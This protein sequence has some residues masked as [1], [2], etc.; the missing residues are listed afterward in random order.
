MKFINSIEISKDDLLKSGGQRNFNINGD[1]GA[2]FNLEIT[3]AAGKF[4]NFIT[5]TF[6]TNAITSTT[7]VTSDAATGNVVYIT[8]ANSNIKIGMT[9]TGNGVSERV[10]VVGVN[11]QTITLSKNIDVAAGATLT[12]SADSGLNSEEM[13]STNY[14][15]LIVFPEISANDTYTVTLE[16]S[17]INDTNLR[18]TERVY[19]E[20]PEST[21]YGDDITEGFTNILF[22]SI[23]INQY[24]NTTVTI[25]A[26]SPTLNGLSVDYSS[27][28]F[29]IVKP[30]NFQV[31]SG[32][33]TSFS[34][35]FT[36]TSA[37]AIAKSRDIKDVYFETTKTQTVNGAVSSS[38]NIVLDSVDNVVVGMLATGTGL[39]VA[40]D[41]VLAVDTVNKKITIN[42]A[43]SVSDGVT[44]TFT[45]KGALGP[46]AYGTD[47]FFTNLTTTLT[48]LTVT[49]AS[50]SSDSTTLTLTSAAYIQDGST[51]IIKG[52]G[53]DVSETATSIT[54][55]VAGSD[56]ITLSAAKSVEAGQTLTVEGTSS[57]VTIT[58][59]VILTRMGDTDFT[60]TLQIDDF[61]G[62]GVL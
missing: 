7:S 18:T 26:S 24:V 59:D 11:S 4:Y 12:F 28:S 29:T 51:T 22:K 20:D 9:V 10:L 58:G 6:E 31:N 43:R 44:I 57:A 25:N 30:R 47:L 61:I 1:K 16:A 49:V 41:T 34:W 60:S 5:Q 50:A 45:A 39:S 33:K 35:T 46:T 19:D 21:T 36:T 32:F 52:P 23:T 53:I 38:A 42:N 2:F 62:I 37:S 15:G 3:N 48:P 54:E 14:A 13:S 55:R 17:I 40:G 8:A 56:N 27:N